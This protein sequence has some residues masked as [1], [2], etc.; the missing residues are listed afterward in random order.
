[1]ITFFC[2]VRRGTKQKQPLPKPHNLPLLHSHPFLL[3]QD[4][5]LLHAVRKAADAPV[6]RNDAMAWHTRRVRI[7]VQR[8]PS[9][10]V[11]LPLA[12]ERIADGLVR[13]DAS[14]RDFPAERVTTYK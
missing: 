1:M 2:M 10:P 4:N 5:L 12:A 6:A 13:R 7:P 8:S 3:Q 9:R 14:A 11:H